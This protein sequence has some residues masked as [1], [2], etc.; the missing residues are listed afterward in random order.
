MSDAVARAIEKADLLLEETR[1]AP[2]R[3]RQEFEASAEEQ[4]QMFRSKVEMS[5]SEDSED[6][7]DEEASKV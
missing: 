1:D 4:L 6:S 7:G 2:W 5:L 3:K